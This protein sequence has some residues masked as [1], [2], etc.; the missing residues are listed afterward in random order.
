MS[1][2]IAVEAASTR[3][4][5]GAENMVVKERWR[6]EE[7]SNESVREGMMMEGSNRNLALFH[8]VSTLHHWEQSCSRTFL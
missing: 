2:A 3:A 8:S 1:C 4:M 5:R 7:D 6:E